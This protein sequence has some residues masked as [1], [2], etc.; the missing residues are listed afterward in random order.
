MGVLYRET[1]RGGGVRGDD[2]LITGVWGGPGAMR[3]RSEKH[4]EIDHGLSGGQ[5]DGQGTQP[6]RE[7]M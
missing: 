6:E 5:G 1:T 2:M 7:H 4:P 3:R